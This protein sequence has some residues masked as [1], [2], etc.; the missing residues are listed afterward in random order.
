MKKVFKIID[1]IYN[2]NVTVF[3]GTARQIER[4]IEK[5]I[6]REEYKVD[7]ACAGS[8]LTF[9]ECKISD[10]MY[11][12][13][14]ETYPEKLNNVI[15]ASHECNHLAFRIMEAVNIESEEAHC[16]YHDYMLKKILNQLNKEI[17]K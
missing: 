15:T 17:E 3:V 7:R 12:I 1:E 5:N 10:M 14:L 8:L 9:E 11:V 16:Y 6:T 4:Y 2:S 13:W